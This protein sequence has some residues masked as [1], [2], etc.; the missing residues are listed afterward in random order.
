MNDSNQ[1]AQPEQSGDP[2]GNTLLIIGVILALLGFVII[3]F[4][5]FQFDA[6]KDSVLSPR[7]YPFLAAVG[8]ASTI[9]GFL[10]ALIHFIREG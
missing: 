2:M 5:T 6:V 4:A 10:L 9:T 1:P 8:Y 7:R 3:T